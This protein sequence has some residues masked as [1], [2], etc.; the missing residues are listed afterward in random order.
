M[1]KCSTA[2]LLLAAVAAAPAGAGMTCEILQ[3]APEAHRV[4]RGDTLWDIAAIFLK[5][6]WCWPQVWERNRDHVANPHLIYPGQLI[7]LD[8]Q[9][10][11]LHAAPATNGRADAD[12]R[13]EI[14]LTPV[15]R[16]VLLP[17]GRPIP[18]IAPQLLESAARFRL[19]TP[20]VIAGAARIIGFSDRRRMVSSGDMAYA[21]G[22]VPTDIVLDIVRV[23]DPVRDPDSGAL[24]ALPLL[25]IGTAHY[26]R[27]D[28]SGLHRVLVAQ[29][30]AEVVAGDLL[31]R[32]Q[33]PL[34]AVSAL[35]P[36]PACEGKIAA[37]LRGGGGS[38]QGDVAILNCGQRKGL[39]N[40]SLVAVMKHVRIGADDS[41]LPSRPDAQPV[42]ALL[43]FDALEQAALALVMRSSDA[44]G[45]GD[46]IGALPAPD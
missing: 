30:Q 2:A 3:T 43:V 18:L 39:N 23:L 28:G 27:Q 32:A 42:A 46:A 45:A 20:E 16:G 22:K 5:N 12:G 38:G 41:P 9:A 17:E 35:Q 31:L 36:A 10:G 26:L 11:R 4:Q 19:A 24:L 37:L 40:G 7:L 34:E 25:R 29:A 21:E 13:G 44:I 14:R 6:P 15:A 8:R 1:K 33:A